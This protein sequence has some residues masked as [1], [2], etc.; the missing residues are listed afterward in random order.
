[1]GASDLVVKV[2]VSL[3]RHP[4][5]HEELARIKDAYPRQVAEHARTL[6]LLGLNQQA[7]ADEIAQRVVDVLG[8]APQREEVGMPDSSRGAEPMAH[9]VLDAFG[10]C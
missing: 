7:M 2:Q 4:E 3:A 8:A 5:L 10:P 1:M 9:A 6:M